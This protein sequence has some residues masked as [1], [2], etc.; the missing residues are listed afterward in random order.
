MI[1]VGKP[2]ILEALPPEKGVVQASAGTGK[3]Y[4]LERMVIDLIL[5]GLRLEQI[6][7]VTF[8]EKAT[9]ELKARIRGMLERMAAL[10]EGYDDQGSPAWT[11]GEDQL[12]ALGEA[13]R[14]FD[15]A[16]IST[17]HGFCRRILQESAF[18]GGC[19]LEQELTDGRAALGR[20][21]RDVIRRDAAEPPLRDFLRDVLGDGQTF[22]GIEELLWAA[23]A[24]RGTLL[25]APDGDPDELLAACPRGWEARWP[26]LE[27]AV[28]ALALPGPTKKAFLRR[29]EAFFPLLAVGPSAYRLLQA[30]DFPFLEEK[31]ILGKGGAG[32]PL[33]EWMEAFRKAAGTPEAMLV[34]R[35]LPLVRRRLRELKDAEGLYD[36]DDSILQVEAALEGPRG[37]ELAARLRERYQAALIDEFQDTDQAQWRIFR[38]LFGTPG[39]RLYVI[40]DPKQAI[41][42]FRGGDLPTYRQATAEL[43]G[44]RPPEEL[45][46]N[47]RSTRDVLD[48][49]NLIFTGGGGGFF[50]DPGL[51]PAASAVRCGNPRLVAESGDGRPLAPVRVLRFGTLS[52]G[53][54][55]WRGV[56]RALAREIKDLLQRERIRFGDPGAEAP[57]K[58]VRALHCGDV[59][60]LVEKR[61]QGLEIA[62]ALRLEGIPCA[63][64]KQDGLLESAEAAD[65][66][67]CLAA[68]AEP[69]NRTC[70]ARAL[71]TPFFGY[72]WDDL[73]ALRDLPEDHPALLRLLAW[74]DLARQRRFPRLF[75]ALHAGSGLVQRLRI[76]AAGE[77]SLTNHLHLAELLTRQARETGADLEDLVRLM[78][79]WRDGTELPPGE[80]GSLQ[81]LEG[82]RR[83]VQ[84]LTMHQ[85]KGLEA[86][87]VALYGF[88]RPNL[89]SKVKRFHRGAER[90]LYLGSPPEPARTAV[91]VE[92]TA[93]A[94]RLLYVA[95]TRAQ[96]QL[97]LPCFIVD[98]TDA[99]G[100]SRPVHPEGNYRILNRRLRDILEAGEHGGLF[101]EAT[102][103][104]RLLEPAE[105]EPPA[106]LGDWTLP[107]PPAPVLPDYQAARR[108]A[109]PPFAASYTS[110]H[111]LGGTGRDEEDGLVLD[112][113]QAATAAVPGPDELPRGARTGI[114]LHRLLEEADLRS[115]EGIP[116]EAWWADEGRRAWIGGVLEDS[117]FPPVQAARAARIVY[118]AL[119]APLSGA[120]LARH[121]HVLR[122]LGFLARFLD[123][124]DLLQGFMDV[125]FERDGRIHLL[126]WKSDAL[127]A[128]DA[129]TLE[130]RVRS[131]YLVQVR[132][133]L[134]VVLDYFG[135]EDPEA[136]ERRFADIHY[137]FLRGLPGQGVWSWHP[138]WSDV[139]AWREDLRRLHGEVA[140]V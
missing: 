36:H 111:A 129:G 67:D 47:H 35:L 84:I 90:C 21:W 83:A 39:R 113:E 79:R 108:A 22:D 19:L 42:G 30:W 137:V 34:H 88:T 33:W 11:L 94:E 97:V 87:I 130:A 128:Y 123:T 20:A 32:H 37:P 57:A 139:L 100:G 48:A 77:R 69:R 12:R 44:G 80:D 118:E 54:N 4:V 53:R 29:L 25:P 15:R 46:E 91:E 50:S 13:L 98:K 52:G 86:P 56:A 124:E 71:V 66:L 122:E 40:G 5:G 65:L 138:A 127:D 38:R 101:Q 2:A 133:Y 85:S 135:I 28:A 120:P 63:F 7:V 82:E 125:V 107:E 102:V 72:A 68:V 103:D 16:T 117:G 10:P 6:L 58:Q 45:R 14:G 140:H 105:V 74:Q 49:C 132:I 51:Y 126:D 81:R 136:Y 9:L 99:K 110:L 70:Q 3:T 121:E 18:E 73:E 93:E 59:Q 131:Q 96:A 60:V 75:E 62:D 106:G 8:T 24:E 104:S 134:G 17:I 76:R 23:H 115:A 61:R 112:G 92:R 119:R 95:L 114:L 1:R 55:L 64:F 78:K 27:A 116:F 41:Y 89:Q 43:L 31:D 109:R 26:E